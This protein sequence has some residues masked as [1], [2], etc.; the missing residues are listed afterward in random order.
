MR[1]ETASKS[2]YELWD[3][4]LTASY[5]RKRKEHIKATKKK[6]WKDFCEEV[7]RDREDDR[8]KRS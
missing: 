4:Q 5:K 1:W 2:N 8:A 6:G 3:K 7:D